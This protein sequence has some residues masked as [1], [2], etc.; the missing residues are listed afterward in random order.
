ML[1]LLYGLY[2]IILKLY[3]S[4]D[5]AIELEKQYEDDIDKTA[6]AMCSLGKACGTCH[7]SFRRLLTSQLANEVNGWSGKYIK[8]CN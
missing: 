3:S 5:N 8:D 1:L 6:L 7:A 4:A 2:Q